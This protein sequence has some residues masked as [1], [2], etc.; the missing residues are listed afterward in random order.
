MLESGES[1]SRALGGHVGAGRKR[2]AK[3]SELLLML[4]P[5]GTRW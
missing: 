2:L 3:V 4:T 5:C 1:C